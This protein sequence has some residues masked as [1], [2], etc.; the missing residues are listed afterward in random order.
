MFVGVDVGTSETK[1]VL[2]DRDGRVLAEASAANSLRIPQPGWA[3]HD[4]DSDWWGNFC[5]LTKALFDRIDISPTAVE[6]VG[7]SGIGPC[8]LAVDDE[9]RPLRPAILYGIDTRAGAQIERLD[10]ELGADAILERTGNA[11]T[12]QSAGPKVAW[13]R[14][15]HPEAF[16]ATA[17]FHT[18]QSFLAARLTGEHIMDRTTAAY[19]GPFYDIRTNAWID[20]WVSGTVEP[21]RLPRLVWPT[22]VVGGISADAARATGLAAGTPVIAGTADAP[23]EAVSAGVLAPGDLMIM[24]GSSIFMIAVVG[25]TIVDP[26]M[27]AAPFVFE[28]TSIVAGGTS[29]AGTL[30]RWL[31]ELLTDE[32]DSAAVSDHYGDFAAWAA[33]SPPGANGLD[34]LPY[35]SGERTPIHDPDAR[36][37]IFGL[38]LRH[39]R[40]DVARSALEGIA[41]GIRLNVEVMLEIGV[42]IE[43]IRAVGGGVKNRAWLQTV[44]DCLGRRQEVVT[45]RGAAYGDAILAAIGAGA[46]RREDVPSWLAVDQSVEPDAELADL[47]DR[48]ASRQRRLYESTRTLMH[49]VAREA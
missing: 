4:A 25:E 47:Y 31:I 40:A 9:V 17:M 11:L 10:D 7:C 34:L 29:T 45:Q 8:V 37:V 23:A 48:Q 3:E 5:T 26:R 33:G 42:P 28:G 21:E 46:L 20:D 35:L 14:D 39:S 38:S 41:Q 36:G 32:H 19:W 15:E 24:Y 43:R 13:L 22:E 2:V 6:A 12:S 49:E 16:A 1:A 30:T 18:C 27:W 44:S